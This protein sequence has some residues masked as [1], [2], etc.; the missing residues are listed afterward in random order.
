[1]TVDEHFVFIGKIKGLS[2]TD[3]ERQ[4]KFLKK[5]LELEE[6][7]NRKAEA[8]SGGNKRKLCCA[9]SLIA[10]PCI[11]FLDEPTTGVDPIARRSLF[12]ILKHLKR[13]SI[14]L[15]THRMDEAEALCDTIAIMI[16]GSFVCFGS[17]G[18]LKQKYGQGYQILLTLRPDQIPDQ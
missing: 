7:S 15:T 2:N 14:M 6:F 8:L 16:N 5:A 11:E 1:M 9:I 17:P 10:N 12:K 13:S 3:I 18:H 4:K